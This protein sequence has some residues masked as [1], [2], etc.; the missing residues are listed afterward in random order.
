MKNRPRSCTR[1]GIVPE[2]RKIEALLL[3][4][5]QMTRVQDKSREAY[6]LEPKFVNSQKLQL[7]MLMIP[8]QQII[9]CMTGSQQVKRQL[10]N[11]ISILMRLLTYL[12]NSCKPS[13]RILRCYFRYIYR[14]LI[15]IGNTINF[16][17][18][19]KDYPL[20]SQSNY[21]PHRK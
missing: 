20:E 2:L 1:Q 14:H 17:V 16:I 9:N 7:D 19:M 13:S 3:N 21:L 18:H 5:I 10:L 12:M 6:Q 8:P 4:Y 11:T 15:A